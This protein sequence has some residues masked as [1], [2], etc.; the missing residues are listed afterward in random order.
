MEYNF[1][2]KHIKGS[3]NSTTD[4]LSRLP[5]CSPGSTVAPFPVEQQLG[6]RIPDPIT[7]ME[8]ELKEPQ[9]LTTVNKVEFS[10]EEGEILSDVAELAKYPRQ[11]VVNVSVAEVVGDVPKAAWDILPLTIKEVAEA[12][13]TDKV[14]SKLYRAIKAGVLNKNDKDV[15]KF[16][17][18]FDQLYIEDEVIYFGTRVVIPTIHHQR[19]MQELHYRHV[20]VGKMKQTVRQVF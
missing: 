9:E 3:S 14:Y 20:G 10:V 13:R 5:I 2:V 17:G 19:L 1:T 15:S 6:Q 7:R 4:S 8:G 11:E 18:S 12:T 16:N